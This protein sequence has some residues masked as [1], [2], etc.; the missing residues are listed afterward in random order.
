MLEAQIAFGSVSIWGKP[1][2][3]AISSQQLVQ[4]KPARTI[5]RPDLDCSDSWGLLSSKEKLFIWHFFN[6]NQEFSLAQNVVGTSFHL[7]GAHWKISASE[8]RSF[9]ERLSFLSLLSMCAFSWFRKSYSSRKINPQVS[10]VLG[11]CQKLTEMISLIPFCTQLLQAWA[12]S[13]KDGHQGTLAF[14]PSW[15]PSSHW[16]H[17]NQCGTF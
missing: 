1:G 7:H 10:F 16:T 3:T 11:W 8:S 14:L 4:D 5:Q 2:I 12:A 15:Q 9:L 13:S 17:V 6:P